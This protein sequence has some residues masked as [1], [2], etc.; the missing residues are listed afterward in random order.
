MYAILCNT[1]HKKETYERHHIMDHRRDGVERLFEALTPS[2]R[3]ALDEGLKAG[4]LQAVPSYLLRILAYHL[5]AARVTSAGP[6]SSSPSMPK[7]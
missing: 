7:R 5:R 2:D 3:K 6:V 1:H 4:T